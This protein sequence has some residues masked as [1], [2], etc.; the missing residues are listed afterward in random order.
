MNGTGVASLTRQEQYWYEHIQ[1]AQ[2]SDQTL[3][4]YA[5]AQGLSIKH[6]YNYRSK[7]RKKGLLEPS[8]VKP[9]VK[10][11]PPAGDDGATIVLANGIRIHTRC[12]VK[13]LSD[14]IKRLL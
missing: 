10:V 5:H 3:T 1:Q 14:L 6:F 13:S 7:L 11:Q 2:S 12:D 8:A 9:F 4:D